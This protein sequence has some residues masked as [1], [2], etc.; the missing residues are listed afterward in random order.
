MNESRVRDCVSGKLNSAPSWTMS[1]PLGDP[2]APVEAPPFPV[3]SLAIVDD[4]RTLS[5]MGGS[6]PLSSHW[7]PASLETAR[8]VNT[9]FS[10]SRRM[11]ILRGASGYSKKVRL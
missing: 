1:F 2:S 3:P 9:L 4:V 7:R 11:G 10:I 8:L 6:D 5:K